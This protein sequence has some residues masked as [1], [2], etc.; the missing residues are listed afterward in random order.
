MVVGDCSTPH[1]F[2]QCTHTA[3]FVVYFA[4]Q[5]MPVQQE[6]RCQLAGT[7]FSRSQE[8]YNQLEMIEDKQPL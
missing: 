6:R 1:P 7:D 3:V 2:H 4:Q 8:T 5:Q